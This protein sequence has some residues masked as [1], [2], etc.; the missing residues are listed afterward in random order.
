MAIG[1][2][3]REMSPDEIEAIRLAQASIESAA[4][5]GYNVAA[6]DNRAN[7]Q[8]NFL[9]IHNLPTRGYF[10]QQPIFGQP[11]VVN[12]LLLIQGLDEK[13]VHNRFTEI[14]Q[15][16][17]Q[18][19]NPLEITIADEI[20]LSYWLRENTY[21]GF[22]FSCIGYQCNHC[23][24][25]FKDDENGGMKF[26]ELSFEIKN[27]DELLKKYNRQ[28]IAEFTLP[29]GKL[30]RLVVPRRGHISRV[31]AILKRDYYD[32]G[33]QPSETDE[34]LYHLLVTVDV[35][36]SDLRDR[37][38]IV[39]SMSPV[40]YIELRKILKNNAFRANVSGQ[41]TCP[42]CQETTKIRSY[43]FRPEIF[44]PGL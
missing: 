29:S 32:Y 26:T 5:A 22:D 25:E 8:S 16:R 19:I 27:L 24:H 17:I 2:H 18:G 43:P 13:N 12:D 21:P 35:G 36:V 10:Y 30:I 20:Y 11:L 1:Q 31:Q 40:D 23:Q 4:K 15:R 38:D 33:T 28:G 39:K 34:E 14:F 44:F 37:V 3:G 42:I 41:F 6:P 9:E 7:E